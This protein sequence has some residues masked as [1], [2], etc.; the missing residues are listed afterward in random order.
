MLNIIIPIYRTHLDNYEVASLQSAFKHFNQ[1]TITF[2][3]PENLDLKFL[4]E[5]N[6]ITNF[7]VETF[8]PEYFKNIDGYNKLLLEAHFYERFSNYE[9]ILICQTDAYV[10]KND[11]LHWTQAKYDYIG[12]PWIGSE[13]NFINLMFEKVNKFFRK[14]I[15]KKEKN[16]ERLFKVGN[17]GFSLRKVESFIKIATI[18]KDIISEFTATKPKNDY[19]IEDVFWSLYVSKKYNWYKIPN[20]NEALNFCIDR[21]PKLSLK[22]NNNN[23]PMACHGFNKKKVAPFWKKYI[24]Y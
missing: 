11:I 20:W 9:Y 13:R 15:G 4:S 10:F 21:K 3:C 23:L 12:A 14:F 2:V 8:S 1:Y 16:T 18:E 17:G 7:F 6:F 24:S 22:L 5:H 19:Y